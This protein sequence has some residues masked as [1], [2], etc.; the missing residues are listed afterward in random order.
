MLFNQL[1]DD[2]DIIPLLRRAAESVTDW[3]TK[4]LFSR[5]S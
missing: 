1:S 3:P 4:D 5:Y 2:W